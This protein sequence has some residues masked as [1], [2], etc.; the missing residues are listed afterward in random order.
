MALL[1]TVWAVEHFRSYIGGQKVIIETCHQP[2]TFLNRQRLREERVSNSCVA[3]WMMALQGYDVEVKYTQNH[4]MALSQG[5]AECH[6]CDCEGQPSPQSLVVTTPSL[7]SNH[8]TTRPLKSLRGQLLISHESQIR[9]GTGI[10][11]VNRS[12]EEPYNY[13]LGNKSQY[14]EIAAVSKTF[15]V[16]AITCR[17]AQERREDPQNCA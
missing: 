5:L 7:P 15:A 14:V 13:W 1:A 6:H 12:V 17:Q 10:I 9:A 8:L 2:V 11:W 3:S 16:N 4:K